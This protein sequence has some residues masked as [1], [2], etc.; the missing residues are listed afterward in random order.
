MAKQ[1]SNVHYEMQDQTPGTSP[2]KS[3][4]NFINIVRRR[5]VDLG[6]LILLN[7]SEATKGSKQQL[8]AILEVWT[9]TVSHY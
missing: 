6:G 4:I 7:F 1:T 3:F 5:F 8:Q 2:E 9:T